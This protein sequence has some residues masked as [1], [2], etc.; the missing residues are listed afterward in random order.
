MIRFLNS[1]KFKVRK[2][3]TVNFLNLQ[4]PAYTFQQR[5][6]NLNVF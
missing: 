2:S 4:V 3:I 1:N 6:H 5:M